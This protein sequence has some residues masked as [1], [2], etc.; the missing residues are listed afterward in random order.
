MAEKGT[1]LVEIYSSPTELQAC[2]DINDFR[3]KLQEFEKKMDEAPVKT[4]KH[5]EGFEYVPIGALEHDFKKFFFGLWEWH[6]TGDPIIVV[7]EIVVRGKIRAF[8][9]VAGIWIERSGI[10]ASQ[11]RM[12]KGSQLTDIN[13][14]LKTALQMDAPHAETQ[15][16][17]NA[18]QKFG[19][20][21]G[22]GLFSVSISYI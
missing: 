4:L 18:A 20:R 5:K 2:K 19:K 6:I 1:E 22:G 16:F 14:K 8:H 21:F 9:P 15:A 13:S 3:I 12:A 11:I 7:N 10:G 17:K